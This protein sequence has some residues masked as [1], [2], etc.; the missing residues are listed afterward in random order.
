MLSCKERL[1]AET[2]R[3]NGAVLKASNKTGQKEKSRFGLLKT[4]PSKPLLSSGRRCARVLALIMSRLM[5]SHVSTMPPPSATCDCPLLQVCSERH[6]RPHDRRI[7]SRNA[8]YAPMT[9][10]TKP[11]SCADLR[12]Q[13]PLWAVPLDRHQGRT[14]DIRCKPSDIPSDLCEQSLM[15]V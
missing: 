11:P 12:R 9:A 3:S 15:Q 1:C 5:E 13:S 8:V 10:L 7:T 6:L 2:Q 14:A 4:P